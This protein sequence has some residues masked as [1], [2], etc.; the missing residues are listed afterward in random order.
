MY[1]NAL[2]KIII[3]PLHNSNLGM[4]GKRCVEG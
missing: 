2:T 3:T 1:A 4:K